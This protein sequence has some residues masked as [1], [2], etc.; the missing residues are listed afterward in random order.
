MGCI[1][2]SSK[3]REWFWNI[4]DNQIKSK[5]FNILH[6]FAKMGEFFNDFYEK[7]DGFHL[8]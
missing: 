4:R 1:S 3:N 6:I 8:Y 5:Y 7:P 2:F